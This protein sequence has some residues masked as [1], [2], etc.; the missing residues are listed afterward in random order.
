MSRISTADQTTENQVPEIAVLDSASSPKDERSLKRCRA[1]LLHR[2]EPV[3]VN[4]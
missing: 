4:L 2:G 3:S 1:A